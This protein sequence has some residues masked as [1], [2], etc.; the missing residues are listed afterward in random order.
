[1]LF[2]CVSVQRG[3]T[4]GGPGPGLRQG[5]KR[6]LCQLPLWFYIYIFPMPAAALILYLRVRG[7]ARAD[8][9]RSGVGLALRPQALPMPA[10]ALVL[11]LNSIDIRTATTCRLASRAMARPGLAQPRRRP[12][13]PAEAACRQRRGTTCR[14]D[15]PPPPGSPR[16]DLS[17]LG[18]SVKFEEVNFV[19]PRLTG[20]GCPPG[21][22]CVGVAW[23][24]AG[25]GLKTKSSCAGTK[26]PRPAPPRPAQP[27]RRPGLPAGATCCSGEERPSA[28]ACLLCTH[29]CSPSWLILN[30]RSEASPSISWLWRRTINAVIVL[31]AV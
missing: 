31:N 25:R 20:A 28:P 8:S 2:A 9:R 29:A 10:A 27:R 17:P 6:F 18:F 26:S 30:I 23:G 14:P 16:V 13:L 24:P 21:P 15:L 1:L 5:R 22:L 12:N 7:T 3:L 19:A 11:Y 4:P